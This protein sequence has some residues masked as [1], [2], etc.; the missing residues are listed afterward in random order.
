MDLDDFKAINEK[1]GGDTA[2]TN[3]VDFATQH[4]LHDVKFPSISLRGSPQRNCQREGRRFK[5]GRPLHPP[6]LLLACE[7]GWSYGGFRVSASRP[8]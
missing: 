4:A 1:V 3:W 8:P 2:V 5:S 6:S 7:L